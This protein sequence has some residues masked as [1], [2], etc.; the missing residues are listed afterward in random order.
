MKSKFQKDPDE[1]ETKFGIQFRAVN[2][3]PEPQQD[4][5]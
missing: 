1:I 4:A 2:T 5:F 3:F